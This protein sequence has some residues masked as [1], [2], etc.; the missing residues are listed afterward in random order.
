MT[1][2][3]HRWRRRAYLSALTGAAAGLAGCPS[4]NGDERPTRTTTDAR[5]ATTAA[6]RT[7]T[8]TKT[9]T[10]VRFDGGGSAAFADALDAVRGEPGAVLQL[11]AGTYRFDASQAPSYEY[12]FDDHRV[13]FDGV[14]LTDVTIAGPPPDA[15]GT[16][17]C[18]LADP[19]RGFLSI[20][21]PAGATAAD[22]P[23]GPTVRDL[24]VRHDPLP[25]TQGRIEALTDDRRAITL[26]LEEGFPGVEGPPF[27]EPEPLLVSANVFTA[28]GDR[29]RRVTGDARSNFKRFASIEPAAQRRVALRLADGIEPGGLAVG[30]RLALVPRHRNATLF[31]HSDLIEPTY[32]RVT[33]RSTPNF[34]FEF[35][36]CERPVLRD[37]AVTPPESGLIATNADGVHCN[38]CPRGPLVERCTFRRTSDDSVVVDAELMAVRE[39]VDDRTVRVYADFGTR[40]GGGDRLTSTT[41]RLERRGTL[42]PVEKVDQRGGGITTDPVNPE[43]LVFSDPIAERLSVGD[44]LIGPRMRNRGTVVRDSTVRAT[45]ARFLRFGGVL[46]G[47]VEN[48]TFLGTNSDG[49]EIAGAGDVREGFSDLKGWSEDV[50]VRGNEI[51]DTGLVGVP[52]GVPRAVFVGVDG[53]EGLA[54]APSTTGRP[55]RNVRIVDNTIRSVAGHGIEVADIDGATVENNRIEGF[56]RLSPVAIGR[57]GL[58]VRNAGDVTVRNTTV[59]TDDTDAAGFGWRAESDSV[60]TGGNEFVVA[61]ERRP[62]TVVDITEQ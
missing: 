46:G 31:L 35:N 28:D 3:G 47:T 56:G 11:D 49:I 37:S 22:R 38:N 13:H 6:T 27:A 17:E 25:Y 2:S 24:A 8:E 18:V 32:E 19:T 58:G 9:E 53:G 55:H 60:A 42:P 21:N 52:S 45:R 1:D 34:V 54:P 4:E 20:Q 30:R 50:L 36:A 12:P 62:A 57:Y 59:A 7:K 44:T 39:L 15:G 61:G 43:L 16:A 40:V 29:L 48:N 41:P 23:R 26:A 51:V 33:V 5:T 14:G 10:V